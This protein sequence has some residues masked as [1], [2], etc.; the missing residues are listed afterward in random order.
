MKPFIL[1]D[2]TWTPEAVQALRKEVIALRDK[3][4]IEHDFNA[5]V[6]LSVAIG[7]LHRLAEEI[8]GSA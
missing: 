7:L 1:N 8:D 5:S 3:A 4:L 2:T 6:V